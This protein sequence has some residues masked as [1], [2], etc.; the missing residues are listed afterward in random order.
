MQPFLKLK[1]VSQDF[2]ILITSIELLFNKI[3]I[4]PIFFLGY[5]CWVLPSIISFKK[6]PVEAFLL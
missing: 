6:K 5:L 4:S 1:A 2:L 3:K